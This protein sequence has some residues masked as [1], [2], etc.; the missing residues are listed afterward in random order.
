MATKY[1]HFTEQQKEQARQTDIAEMLRSQGETLRRSGSEYEWR[2]G[3]EKVTVRGN[4]WFHQYEEV[5]GDA[6][7]FV[8][9]FYN[10]DY[11]EAMEYLLGGCAGTLMVPPPVQRHPK[12][13]FEL[14]EKNDNMRRVFAYLLNRRGI[15]R[16]VLYA[17]AH[18]GM[19]YESADYAYEVMQTKT[20]ADY[21][22][23]RPRAQR[24][25]SH[26]LFTDDG[27]RIKLN[28]VSDELNVYEGNVWTVIISL[29]REDAQRLGYNTGER[30]RDMLRTQT[31]KELLRRVLLE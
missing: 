12:V 31:R 2:D 4:L 3:S 30:W 9:R 20:Y 23:T 21:I 7:D 1:I 26:G 17:F 27:V 19:I 16:N 15:D 25:G 18:K 6:I 29:R 11:P 13:P 24:F 5:G 22:A 8:R 10:K 14:P 28:E